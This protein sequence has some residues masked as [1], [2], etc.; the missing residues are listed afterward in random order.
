MAAAGFT[1]YREEWW[2]FYH[3]DQFWGLAT[4]CAARYGPAEAPRG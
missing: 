2:H 1:A 4:D 3:G